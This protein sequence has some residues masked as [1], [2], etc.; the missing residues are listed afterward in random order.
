MVLSP[1]RVVPPLLLCV[2]F[3]L[4]AFSGCSV[5]K[6]DDPPLADS[7]FTRVLIDLHLTT[8]RGDRLSKLPPAASDSLFVHHGIRREDFDATL[9]YYT[10]RPGAFESLYDAVI[11]TL[12]A[13]KSR[14]RNLP[15]SS[16]PDSLRPDVEQQTRK[17]P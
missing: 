17:R 10:R 12:N 2:L 11:D 15:A 3:G 9:R 14:A 1:N 8:A 4:F 5:L 16:A 13:L 7:T 6:S